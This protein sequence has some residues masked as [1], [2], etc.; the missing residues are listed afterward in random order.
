M[1]RVL[2]IIETLFSITSSDE[3][4]SSLVLRP[5]IPKLESLAMAVEKSKDIATASNVLGHRQISILSEL[6]PHLSD[7]KQASILVTL[8]SPF[9]KKPSKVIPETVKVNMINIISNLFPLVF[10]LQVPTS[11]SFHKTFMLLSQLMQNRTLSSHLRLPKTG[12]G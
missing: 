4:T 6:A 2:D 9:L 1:S 10:D 5:Y 11:L 8:L 7:A 3:E 12:R